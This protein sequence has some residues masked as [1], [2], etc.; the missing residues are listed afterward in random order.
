MDFSQRLGKTIERTLPK[1]GP[2]VRA[3]LAA[4]VQPQALALMA[5][6]LAAWVASHAVG[7]GEI[8]DV[9]VAAGGMLAVGWAVFT[10][11]DELYE[12][13]AH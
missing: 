9:I 1:V 7:L 12:F 4:L 6:I 2:E 10:G 11:I 8:I 3:Q 13:A 5:V